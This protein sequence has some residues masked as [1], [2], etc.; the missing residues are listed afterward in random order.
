VISWFIYLLHLSPTDA[1]TGSEASKSTKKSGKA[2]KKSSK[3]N[4]KPQQK[5]KFDVESALDAPLGVSR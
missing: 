3:S 2:D 1:C 4:K 5:E